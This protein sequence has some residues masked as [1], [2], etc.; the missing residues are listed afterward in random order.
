MQSVPAPPAWSRDIFSVGV[1]GTNGKTTTTAQIAAI[2]EATLPSA[3]SG[4][5]RATTV[6]YFLGSRELTVERSY[7]GF[8]GA[9]DDARQRG[10]RYAALEMTSEA[11]ARGF[12]RA[13]P[14]RVGVFTNLTHDHL[15]AH[16]NP[17]HYLAS[18]A[19]LFVALPEDG[20]AVLNAG[21]ETAPLLREI[22]PSGVRVLSYATMPEGGLGALALLPSITVS[23]VTITREGTRGMLTAHDP[24]L[25][26]GRPVEVRVRGIGVPF[27]ENGMAAI[28]GA[29]AAG[30]PLPAAIEAL[31]EAPVPPGRFELGDDAGTVAVD[32]AHT[33]DAIERTL[34]TART[35]AQ[36]VTV[37]FGAGGDR[38]KAKRPLMGRAA[39]SA[40]RVVITTDN[41]R[42][43]GPRAI[44]DAIAAGVE[45]NAEP[46]IVLDRKEAIR[47][48]IREA[49]PGGLVLL[50]GKGH[51]KVPF[52]DVDVA[53]D[54][55]RSK[56]G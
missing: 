54:V 3:A 24:A 8:I 37:V 42:S 55:L 36:H 47:R 44:A 10:C 19:Q 48:A 43:E 17:E 16:Q 7:D 26:V 35:L 32:Y 9:L 53:R 20:I 15:D 22:L 38:D 30:A 18:K 12:A 41:P 33:P 25:G 4:V 46:E 14:C 5:F 23:G 39:S 27:M 51:E 11:L 40:S 50:L 52:S 6:G 29:Y 45:G 13:W 21:D 2:L 49:P 34:A 56:T 31:A 28:L 1:T